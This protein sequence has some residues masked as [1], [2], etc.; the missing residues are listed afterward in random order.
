MENKNKKFFLTI[1]YSMILALKDLE[2]AKNKINNTKIFLLIFSNNF[3]L[4]DKR[5]YI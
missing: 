5:N 3:I 4:F 1:F 2:K